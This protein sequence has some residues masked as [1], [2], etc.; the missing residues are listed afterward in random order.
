MTQQN[1]T[2]AKAGAVI[3]PVTAFEQ[4]CLLMWCETT[5]KAVVFDPGGDVA[6]IQAAIKQ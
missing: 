5:R 4:N 3:I 6:K 2:K 1:Q